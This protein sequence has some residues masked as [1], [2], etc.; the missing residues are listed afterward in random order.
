MYG[1]PDP[2]EALSRPW[3]TTLQIPVYSLLSPPPHR[4]VFTC[5]CETYPHR[6]KLNALPCRKPADPQEPHLPFE[7]PLRHCPCLPWP[8]L[9]GPSAPNPW[10]LLLEFSTY[11]V[12]EY[13][14]HS[15]DMGDI[16]LNS[17]RALPYLVL[18]RVKGLGP[19]CVIK[20]SFS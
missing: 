11:S 12:L 6:T 4:P 20:Q 17:A 5:P 14:R 7:C 16:Y 19:N 9:G 2:G 15:T 3:G 13:R 8:E 10:S 18:F 1:L